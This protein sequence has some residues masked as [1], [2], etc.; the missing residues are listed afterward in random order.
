[1]CFYPLVAQ[2]TN[3]LQM[4]RMQYE[5]EVVLN[6]RHR[7]EMYEQEQLF[8]NNATDEDYVETFEHSNIQFGSR[9]RGLKL[10]SYEED[11]EEELG[12]HEFGDSLARF[13]RD[14][15]I[16]EVYGSDFEGD[17]FI[18]HQRYIYW[19][20]V[21]FVPFNRFH[22]ESY[23]AAGDRSSLTIRA[24]YRL[25]V[26]KRRFGRQKSFT[27]HQNGADQGPDTTQS[28]S[29]V[30]RLQVSYLLRSVPCLASV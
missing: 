7:I 13:F 3:I 10:K 27:S 15:N 28:S 1:M 18:G 6:I 8:N 16:V 21:G 4:L 30:Q 17:G 5:K 2:L 20:K 25:I 24:R 9:Q 29:R 26:K 12:F 11:M 19:Y 14:R 23:Q 22:F